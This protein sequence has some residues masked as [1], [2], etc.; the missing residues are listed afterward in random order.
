MKKTDI[1][2]SI[3]LLIFSGVL[4][5]H[6]GTFPVR[7]GRVKVLNAGFYPQLLA[8]ILGIL[9]LLLLVVSLRKTPENQKSNKLWVTKSALFL[10]FITLGMLIIYPF[11]LSSL[12]F[13]VATFIFII[14]LVYCLSDKEKFSLTSILL[15][16]TGITAIIFLV[17]KVFIKIPFPTGY[18]F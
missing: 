9:A 5:F 17:F 12:G 4:Y 7:E 18:L 2:T 1:I 15:V 16:S 8:V 13:V 6:S 14:I 11:L 3:C 10:F